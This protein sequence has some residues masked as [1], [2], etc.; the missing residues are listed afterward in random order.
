[1]TIEYSIENIAS[2][3]EAIL[4]WREELDLMGP[5]AAAEL[6]ASHAAKAP[7]G[8]E[9]EASE[10][11]GY[12]AAR[13]RPARFEPDGSPGYTPGFFVGVALNLDMS[14]SLRSRK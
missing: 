11:R 7:A 1:M 4:D 6:L 13:R 8:A 14:P 9:C 12:A 10:L 3:D 5:F 2:V